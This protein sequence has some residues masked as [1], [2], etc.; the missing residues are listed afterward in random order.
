MVIYWDT[1]TGSGWHNIA[2]IVEP[3]NTQLARLLTGS[4]IEG[5]RL[6]PGSRLEATV[7]PPR[8]GTAPGTITVRA[9]G[10]EFSLRT[11]LPLVPG[12]RV[13]LE[14]ME[15]GPRPLF[16]LR[17]TALDAPSNPTTPGEAR[18]AAGQ[19]LAA[20]RSLLQQALPLQQ[21]LPR[22]LAALQTLAAD[23][24]LPAELKRPLERLFEALPRQQALTRP[25]DLE[26]ALRRL[27]LV[28]P[29][30]G[31][32]NRANHASEG[33][34]KQGL[35]RLIARAEQALARQGAD[36]ATTMPA[37][38]A[39]RGGAEAAPAVRPPLGRWPEPQP[40][41]A[42]TGAQ[43][44]RADNERGLIESLLQQ[45]EGALSRLRLLQAGHGLQRPGGSET[46]SPTQLRLELPY[47]QPD[48]SLGVVA[49]YIE[50]EAPDGRDTREAPEAVWRVRLA[51]DLPRL[52]PVQFDAWLQAARFGCRILV[53]QEA[54]RALFERHL[55]RLRE[56]L[57]AQGLEV[58]G[59]QCQTGLIREP[60]CTDDLPT[61]RFEA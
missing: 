5:L 27:G 2:M 54:T 46:P 47:L 32:S 45:A 52:G 43:A 13:Q 44:S 49:L 24:Q 37:A 58:A 40:P 21:S 22:A 16:S 19:T 25:Q 12:T 60:L 42:A 33:D 30:S 6:A 1:D 18:S 61:L 20:V 55:V 28:P 23:P 35:L 38:A 7:L 39:T 53:E 36:R 4:R 48:G 26:Q 59:L 31:A 51:L 41:Q 57:D 14:V 15:A 34:L 29:E 56:R 8:A 11:D 17:Q 9:G 3:N 50:R 10:L